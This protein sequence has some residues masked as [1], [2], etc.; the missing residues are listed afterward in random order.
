[1]AEGQGEDVMAVFKVRDV[2]PPS[3]FRHSFR[4]NR[5]LLR[6]TERSTWKKYF[7][8]ATSL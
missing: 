1:M 8:L 6:I 3:Q 5:D 4:S 2:L 7:F